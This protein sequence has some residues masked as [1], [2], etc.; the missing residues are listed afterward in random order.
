MARAGGDKRGSSYARRARKV[1]M[2][3]TFGDG[4]TAPCAHCAR[5]LTYSQLEADRIVPGGSYRRDNVQPG[6]RRCNLER[7]DD[8]TWTYTG[9]MFAPA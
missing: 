7:S 2:L 6:C 8:A 4:I 5:P 1:W 9:P 3:A